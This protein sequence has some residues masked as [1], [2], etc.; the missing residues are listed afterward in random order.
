MLQDLIKSK[1]PVI[2]GIPPP[3][4]LTHTH[5]RRKFANGYSDRKG[6][7]RLTEA[8]N[9]ES[10]I[11]I[12]SAS[13]DDNKSDS[14]INI[15]LSPKHPAK[16]IHKTAPPSP[17]LK[18]SATSVESNKQTV[19]KAMKSMELIASNSDD[20]R[21]IIELEGMPEELESSEVGEI[22]M[23]RKWKWKI[24]KETN[25]TTV[26]AL[27]SS[28]TVRP[29]FQQLIVSRKPSP[30]IPSDQQTKGRTLLFDSCYDP[31][32]DICDRL[33]CTPS[34]IPWRSNP[35]Q[36]YSSYSTRV[37]CQ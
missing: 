11:S 27:K 15:L 35:H 30:V 3:P 23:G 25:L 14:S 28:K 2:I 33:P 13:L 12:S 22:H 1:K 24:Y 37:R 18:K 20:D 34:R 26:K 19:K 17:A 4:D 10:I 29:N 31:I 16:T 21:S 5:G 8:S 6:P 36:S 32:A 7:Q 9:K